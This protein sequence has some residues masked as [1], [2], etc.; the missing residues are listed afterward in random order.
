[1]MGPETYKFSL[2]NGDAEVLRVSTDSAW[3]LART[4]TR[5]KERGQQRVRKTKL[6]SIR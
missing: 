1:M 3:F 5:F 4:R 6:S 2:E